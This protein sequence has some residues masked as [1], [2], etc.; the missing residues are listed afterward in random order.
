MLNHTSSLRYAVAGE[1]QPDTVIL[2]Y[3]AS[4]INEINKITFKRIFLLKP[5]FVLFA[6]PVVR[7][8]AEKTDLS[9][10][11]VAKTDLSGHSVAKTEA[12]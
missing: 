9:G 3:G 12:Q 10:R 11:S 1:I 6:C 7:Q 4:E 8:L 2:P 5:V